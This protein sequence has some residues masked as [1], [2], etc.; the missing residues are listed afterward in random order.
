MISRPECVAQCSEGYNVEEASQLLF[1][2]SAPTPMLQV[3]V[4][5]TAD[6]V[7]NAELKIENTVDT[8]ACFISVK[9]FF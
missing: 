2:F 5:A 7:Q 3:L 4:D 6:F 9:L 1:F 8:L